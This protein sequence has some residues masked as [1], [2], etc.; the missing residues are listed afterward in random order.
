MNAPQPDWH[1]AAAA[2]HADG[3]MFIDGKRCHAQAG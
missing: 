3:R 1:V 2:M